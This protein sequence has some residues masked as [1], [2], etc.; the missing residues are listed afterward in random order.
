[1]TGTFEAGTKPEELTAV[2]GMSPYHFS[3]LFKKVQHMHLI[4]GPV[5]KELAKESLAA[6]DRRTVI[7]VGL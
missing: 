2:I 7:Q 1:M 6:P 3:E 4:I 5:S